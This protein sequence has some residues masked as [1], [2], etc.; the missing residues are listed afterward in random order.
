SELPPLPDPAGRAGMFAGVSA[1]RLFCMG[2]ANFP[3]GYPWEGGRKKWH[4]D[5]FMLEPGA[6][7]WQRL[8][9]VLPGGLAYGVSASYNQDIFLVGGSTAT[10]HCAETWRLR[11]V[12]GKLDVKEGPRLPHPLAN[13]A[14][15]RVGSLL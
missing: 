3:E 15:T 8:D 12:Q 11:W 5:V 2:G 9:A 4:N 6:R 14:G 7:Q 1:G 10:A 13:M